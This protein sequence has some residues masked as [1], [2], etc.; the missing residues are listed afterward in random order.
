MI[1]RFPVLLALI[2]EKGILVEGPAVVETSAI[3]HVPEVIPEAET[4]SLL[5]F[6]VALVVEGDS[7]CGY[8]ESKSGRPPK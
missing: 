7:V 1:L 6:I 3:N 4:R 2:E 5:R 8:L